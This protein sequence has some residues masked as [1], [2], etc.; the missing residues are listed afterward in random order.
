MSAV[1]AIELVRAGWGAAL[2]AAPEAIL[3]TVARDDD[4]DRWAI[5]VTRVLGARHLAQSILSGR[6]PTGDVLAMGVWVDGVHAATA[7]VLAIVDRRRARLGVTDAAVAAAWGGAGWRDL[8]GRVSVHDDRLRD[9]LAQTVL[10]HVPAGP[11]LLQRIDRGAVSPGS[12][13]TTSSDAG[14]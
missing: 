3:K 6:R 4:P 7:L 10:R 14:P 12:S 11:A 1:R 13:V 8:G 5:N 2:L 9:R